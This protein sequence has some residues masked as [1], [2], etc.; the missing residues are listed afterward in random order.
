[1]SRLSATNLA[2]HHHLSCDLYL[3]N[4]Y[5]RRGKMDAQDPSELAKA[6]FE[7]GLEWEGLLFTFLD[8]ENL[9]LT[10]PPS[11]ADGDVLSANIEADERDHFFVA[12]VAFWPP[13]ELRNRYLEAGADPVN[14]G[15]AKPDL[16]EIT[17]TPSGITW[18]VIDAKASK[19]VKTSHHVQI[20]F[21]TL[22]LSYL[23]PQ[24][25]FQPAESAAVWLPPAIESNPSLDDLKSI[26]ITL[27]APSIDDFL[28]R[29][30][31]KILSLPRIAVEWHLNPLC[32]G[33]PFETDCE[34]RTVEDGELG[35]I[36]NISLAE[37]KTL[38]TLLGISL[39][40]SPA[41]ASETD[42]ED[43]HLLLGDAG[44]LSKIG[45][46]FPSTL[47]K[48]KRILAVQRAS[49]HSPAVEAARTKTV[50]IIPRR[51]Y[52]CPR[53][54]DIA[55]VIS[56]VVDPASSTGG[57]AAF[58]I[59]VFS[60]IPTFQPEPFHG[61]EATFLPTLTSIL[62]RI[63]ALNDTVRPVPLTQFYVFSAGEQTALQAHLIDSALTST[64]DSD[65][66]VCLGALAQ[67]V[68]L[69]QT[70]FQP[71]LLSGALL[72]FM[73]KGRKAELQAYL[74]RM[75]LHVSTAGTVE[76]LRQRI[77]QEIQRLQ[78]EGRST[79]DDKRTELGQLPRVVV[80]KREV[81]NLLAL[82]V[83]G[84]WDLAQCAFT[85]LPPS[86]MDRKCPTDEEV[87]DSYK[88]GEG[89]REALEDKL[90]QRNSSIYSV[91]QSMRTRLSASG[92]K[93][94]VNDARKL[95]ANFMD[96]CK[97]EHL[98]KLFFM[99]QFEVLAKLTELW[100]ARIDGCPDAPVLEYKETVQGAK[101]LEHTFYLLSGSLDIPAG[102]KDKAFYDYIMTE[103]ETGL[104]D[105]PVEALFDDLSVA[106]LVFPL[107]RNTKAKWDA[108]NPVVRQKLLVA[109]LRDIVVDGQRT[110][111][112]VQTWGGWDVRLVAGHHYRLSPRLV[113]FNT[114]KILSTLLELDI[115][116][117]TSQ[118]DA[119]VPFLQLI[120]D[121]R[122]FGDDP[123]FI[124]TGKEFVKVENN[125]QSMFRQLK[126]LDTSGGAAEALVLKPSQHR[127]VQRILSSRL[128]VCW[129]PPGTGKTYT[130]A[131]ALLRLFE[132]QYR[133]GNTKRKIIFITAMT[134][135]AI[136]AVLS[137]LDHLKDCYNR[138]D[139][140]P[141]E[142]LD[143]VQI[144]H[145]LKGHDH[146]GPSKSAPSATLVY[147]GT[148]YQLYNFSK[149][150]SFEVDVCV[151]DE[152][153]QLALSSAALVLRSLGP[154]G[155]IVIA[156]DSEQLAPIL[157]A[158]YPQLKSRLL[159]GSI[160]DCLMHLSKL[161]SRKESQPPLSPTLSDYS[162]MSS[163]QGTVV[164]LTENF[165][166][167][168]DLGEFVST[169]YSRA[170][171]PQKFQARQLATELKSI[172]QDIGVDLGVDSHVLRDVQNFLLALSD[173]ML[174]KPQSVLRP[175]PITLVRDRRKSAVE[176]SSATVAVGDP[177]LTPTPISLAL[178]RLQTESARP[179]GVGYEAHVRGEAALAAALITSIRRCSPGED[180]FVATPH[181][182]QRQ[183]VKAALERVRVSELAN[184]L[185]GLE[186][187]DEAEEG[188]AR[189]GT[190]TVDTVERL[191]GSE[192]AFV[193]CL[194]SL[195]PSASYDLGF[196]LER[197]RLNV[198]ISRAKTLCILVSSNVVLRPPVSVL[199]SE[200]NAKGYKFLRA[201][202][203]RAWSSVI[204]LDVDNF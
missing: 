192:A 74:D 204:T 60:S 94:L 6:N 64:S 95:T 160:L 19:A 53:R 130:I 152:A 172:E 99:Q 51:N 55:V 24:P 90:E 61:S 89:S 181:R 28:F 37:V 15:L 3:H 107:S 180:I 150:Y 198:A 191:Q 174:R 52:T 73:S 162:A 4:V 201:F 44:K 117:T 45:A 156:G 123:E 177:L 127:A 16:L 178:V 121:P 183:A 66:R 34:K 71:L 195:P 75:G 31:P 135:A 80:L 166:L 139:S 86:S 85:L 179:E 187:I 200:E 144:E 145:V 176:T 21:Y 84:S 157:T 170:F 70:T 115:A 77:Q 105:I 199:A 203:D 91:L 188:R 29:R 63:L 38:R 148:V 46:S 62:R 78:D 11:P 18:K 57:I 12:G 164:Q 101:G 197:R 17:R 30:L 193:I 14:F 141:T 48:A 137:K 119:E 35:S 81:E 151:I 36:P 134:H 118:D 202:E 153:G 65:I 120:L 131:L 171:K 138:I 58:C 149:R 47:K 114:T 83:P 32:R 23:L 194:F 76:A 88:K 159:F 100:K 113:D 158:Q 2:V 96:I 103:D 168:P 68:S 110:K 5:H 143:S 102:D 125:I 112:T 163:S 33:C 42:I 8:D 184:E 129:G 22:C 59:S 122:S 189:V 106:G 165:R 126:D 140:L 26:N 7:R 136:E 87:F 69:L 10:I 182:I 1:M 82:P 72:S 146:P 161:P 92:Q 79:D 39:D 98:R 9:L 50:Q 147:A 108:Q 27:L 190:V 104:D 67:G 43:L 175:P 97:E 128:G 116:A 173:V 56:L 155:R 40:F 20:Y 93:L 185:A 169:I 196:L 111:V 154:Q 124:E 54:E 133:L 49:L 142:W 41:D 25:F 132:V 109:Y 13:P 186:L 167:N